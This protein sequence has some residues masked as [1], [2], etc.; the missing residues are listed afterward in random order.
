M[1]LAPTKLCFR[2]INKKIRKDELAS[3]HLKCMYF[4]NLFIQSEDMYSAG[5]ITQRVES[6]LNT[7]KHL[8]LDPQHSH[9]S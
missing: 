5:V 1:V 7:R 4:F 6:L 3:S 2:G 8:T 9:N